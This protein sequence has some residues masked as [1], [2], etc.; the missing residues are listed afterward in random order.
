MRRTVHF[1]LI[2]GTA[3]ALAVSLPLI[4]AHTGIASPR[5]SGRPA[6]ASGA[7]P[8]PPK[9]GAAPAPPR[10]PT[11]R[12]GDEGVRVEEV[13]RRLDRLGFSPGSAGS[14]YDPAL[15]VAV[16]AFQKANGLPPV[17]QVDLPTWRALARPARI[18]PLVSYGGPAR[19]EIDLRRQLLTAWKGG[20]PA[21]VTHISTGNGESY[22]KK[23]HCGVA[24]TPTGD[25][26]A[27]WRTAG[28]T[29]GPLGE[30]F[31]TVYFNGGIGF[32]GS[33]R[34]PRH[35]ASHGCIR[36]PLHNAKPLFRMIQTGD[37]VYVRRPERDV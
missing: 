16:W 13:R 5:S 6:P 18:R 30:Q 24:V 17:D 29:T 25:F 15:R 23:G 1:L 34:V 14:G 27:W 37:Q 26:R 31:Y 20:R 32:H 3:V 11:L 28:W 19:V 33:E 9:A 10:W 21:L 12:L 7:T 4:L 2:A 36:V 8:Q 35:P 22:C